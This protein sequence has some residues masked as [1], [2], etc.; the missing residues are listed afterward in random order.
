MSWILVAV[1]ALT[2]GSVFGFVVMAGHPR[3]SVRA[4]SCMWVA[5]ALALYAVLMYKTA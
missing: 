4:M 5:L 2:S 3:H 1:L